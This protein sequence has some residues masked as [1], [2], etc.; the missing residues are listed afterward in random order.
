MITVLTREGVVNVRVF[1]EVFSYYDKQIS[2]RG[3][4]G[5]KHV[6]EKSIFS[7]GNKIIITGIRRENEFV[8]KKYKNT[9]Y[10]GIELITKINEDGTVESQGRIEQ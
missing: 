3:A 8:M 7:R 5:K 9:P 2:E 1:G 4:D 6:I 10:H